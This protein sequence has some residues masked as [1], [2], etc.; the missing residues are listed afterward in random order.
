MSGTYAIETSSSMDTYGYLY[1]NTFDPASISTNL[2]AE[3]DDGPSSTNFQISI[4]LQALTRYIVVVTTYDPSTT[5]T[6]SI[7]ASGIA[8][9]IFSPINSS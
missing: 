2:L 8:S 9:V 7:V 5:G 1:N 3:N 6:F 4:Y